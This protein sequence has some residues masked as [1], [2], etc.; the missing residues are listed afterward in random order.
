VHE[1]VGAQDGIGRAG[2]DAQ[3]AA[4]APGFVDDGHM[5]WSF[6]PMF[7]IEW[8]CGQACQYGQPVDALLSTRWALVDGGLPL[9]HSLGVTGAVWKATARALRLGQCVVQA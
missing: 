3:G 9:G 6:S 4:N 7:W 5:A 1:F 2:F 8:Q